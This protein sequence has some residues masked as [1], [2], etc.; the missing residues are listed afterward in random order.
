[1]AFTGEEKKIQAL[2]DEMRFDD[3]STAPPFARL[4]NTAHLVLAGSGSRFVRPWSNLR[5]V[6][7]TAA[8]ALLFSLL[9]V[10]SFLHS[11]KYL[12]TLNKDRPSK[13]SVVRTIFEPPFANSAVKSNSANLD[14]S[15]HREMRK[16]RRG[17]ISVRLRS[18]D[19]R[20]SRL[21]L[22]N[23]LSQWQSPTTTLLRAPGNQLLRF[24]PQLNQ[25]ADEM[26]IFL[27]TPN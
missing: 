14:L 20:R 22:E 19:G 5:L 18:G 16:E 4:A 24:V 21:A 11:F 26:K 7:F 25:P 10:Q 15:S 8:I 12:A 23:S 6:G 13:S 27:T 1:M 2:F 9:T 17:R 3:S